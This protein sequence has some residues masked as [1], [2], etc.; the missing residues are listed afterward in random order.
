M[1]TTLGR[2]AFA[3]VANAV[4]SARASFG[5]SIFG[6]TLPA[7]GAAGAAVGAA[8]AALGPRTN[9]TAPRG[10]VVNKDNSAM[11]AVP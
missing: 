10:S 4:D 5:A 6:V 1:R 7:A 3:A 2:N 11:R 8:V 9:S